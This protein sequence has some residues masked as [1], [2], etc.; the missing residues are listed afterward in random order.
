MPTKKKSARRPGK[1]AASIR[2][3]PLSIPNAPREEFRAKLESVPFLG[4]E[5]EHLEDGRTICI[6]KPGGKNAYGRM[7]VHD[8]MVWV[9][10]DKAKSCWRISH[11]EI[12]EDLQGKIQASP[13]KGKLVIRALKRVCE[14]EEPDAVL[15]LGKLAGLRS[16]LPGEPP[17]LIVKAYKWIF[18]QED[19]N[20]PTGEGRDMAMSGI[21]ELVSNASK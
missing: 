18:G 4:Y 7:K 13:T 21:L 6:T 2:R 14:G 8:F 19:C 10:D 12:K 1:Y 3:V 11:E 9:Y 15:G 20:Y 16:G 5:V 17:D